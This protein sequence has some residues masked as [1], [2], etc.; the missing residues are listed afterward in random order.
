MVHALPFDFIPKLIASATVT[1]AVQNVNMF[2]A[3]N[4]VPLTLSPT[5]IV[6]GSPP[7][8]Y[9]SSNS[10]AAGAL[11]SKRGDTAGDSKSISSEYILIGS[12]C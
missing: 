6:T 12:A 11:K 4:G 7:P 5:T 8:N 1:Q 9:T 3:T 10:D 2:P